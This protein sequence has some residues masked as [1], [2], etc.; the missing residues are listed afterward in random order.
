MSREQMRKLLSEPTE[1]DRLR[2]ENE[3]LVDC[4]R[5]LE[6]YTGCTG[7]GY[8]RWLE[9]RDRALA[10]VDAAMRCQGCE[11]APTGQHTGPHDWEIA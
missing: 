5:V 1:E 7:T 2:V 4:A 9:R 10:A 6:A 8:H 3:V 11:D